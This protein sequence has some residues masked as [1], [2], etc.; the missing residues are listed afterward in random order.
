MPSRK[1][2][3]PKTEP[4]LPNVPP[5]EMGAIKKPEPKARA[6]PVEQS[7]GGELF[8]VDNSDENWKVGN[9][10]R[11]WTNL[12]NQFDIATGYFEIGALLSM[13]GDWQK[14]VSISLWQSVIEKGTN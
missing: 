14:L 3:V 12:S 4:S 9:Y 13:E 6:K 7:H 2:Q 11:E 5:P 8:I 1:S 10:L